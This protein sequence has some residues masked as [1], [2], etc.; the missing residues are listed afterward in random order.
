MSHFKFYS[1]I[2]TRELPSTFKHK[3]STPPT[4]CRP[5]VLIFATLSA[6]SSLDFFGMIFGY[7]STYP[8]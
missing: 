5:V 7:P 3:P 6:D 8:T 1:A 4:E 2:Q